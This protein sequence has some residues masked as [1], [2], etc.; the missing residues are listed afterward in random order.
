MCGP[1]QH[2]AEYKNLPPTS[3]IWA[4]EPGRE[5]VDAAPA[6]CVGR[7]EDIQCSEDGL[8]GG[9]EAVARAERRDTGVSRQWLAIP[10]KTR[11]NDTPTSHLYRRLCRGK[12]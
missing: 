4:A 8:G 9:H 11:Q 2:R 10:G 5:C 12:G 6:A 1:D 7:A 3:H